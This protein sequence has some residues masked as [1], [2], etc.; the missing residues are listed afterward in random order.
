MTHVTND[1][2][3]TSYDYCLSSA[4]LL[5]QQPTRSYTFYTL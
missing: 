4:H 2:L 5:Y 1:P 3:L